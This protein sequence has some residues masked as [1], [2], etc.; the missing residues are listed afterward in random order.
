MASQQ[1]HEQDRFEFRETCWCKGA[2]NLEEVKRVWMQ[3][4][5]AQLKPSIGEEVENALNRVLLPYLPLLQK[6]ILLPNSSSLLHQAESSASRS[7]ELQFTGNIP[8][9]MLTMDKIEDEGASLE[10]ELLESGKRVEIGPESS[11]KI[12]IDVL[13]GDFDIED[14][15]DWTEED[16][17]NNIARPRK[18]KGALLKGKCEIV[19]S[20]GVASVSHIAFTDNSKSMRN[21]TFRLGVKVV[22][23]LP[24]GVVVKAA[25]SESFVVKERRLKS[26]CWFFYDVT[27]KL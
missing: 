7:L 16:Y 2:S 9:T 22:K 4:F 6:P 14:R 26:K 24:P 12:K 25:V 18:T 11:M 19:M 10:V 3:E 20:R 15:D 13:D 17:T 1:L 27:C 23:G 8:D 5:M 21:G